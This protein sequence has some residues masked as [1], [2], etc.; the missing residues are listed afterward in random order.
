MALKPCAECGTEI[1]TQA[2]ACPKCGAPIKA[3]KKAG[4]CGTG[5][6]VVALLILIMA[7]VASLSEKDEQ[8]P[9]Q[10]RPAAVKAEPPE[11]QERRKKL[12]ADLQRQGIFGKIECRSGGATA[13][14]SPRFYL[15]SFDDKQSFAS[16]VYVYCHGRA[17]DTGFVTL[18]D[19]RTGK[20]V[21]TF[22][23]NRG[24]DLE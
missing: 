24:L 1:S 12:I 21:G 3:A 7:I 4:G 16:V 6:G 18:K 14:V 20:D 19:D 22:W 2:T 11:T 10:S 23:G 15:I 8:A 13:W 17:D 9:A 5:V